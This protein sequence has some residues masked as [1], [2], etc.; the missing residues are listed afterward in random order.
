MESLKAL[1]Q[2][3]G[4]RICHLLSTARIHANRLTYASHPDTATL[5]A[6]LAEAQDIL[7]TILRAQDDRAKLATSQAE[8]DGD[9][10][11]LVKI[12]EDRGESPTPEDC[13]RAYF[14]P[15]GT[16]KINMEA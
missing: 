9:A 15:Q 8:M 3:G 16:S 5:R 6:F 10:L 14:L 1:Q 13:I 2:A 4:K 11:R 7:Y 12:Y